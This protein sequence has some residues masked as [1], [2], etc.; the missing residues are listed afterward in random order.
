MKQYEWKVFSIKTEAQIIAMGKDLWQLVTKMESAD[1]SNSG[2]VRFLFKRELPNEFAT[3]TAQPASD[4]IF[5]APT[6][7]GGEYD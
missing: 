6:Y 7:L 5:P 4:P 1:T 3:V 2:G